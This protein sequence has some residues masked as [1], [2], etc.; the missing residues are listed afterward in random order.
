[1]TQRVHDNSPSPA[2]AARQVHGGPPGPLSVWVLADL[3]KDSIL[4]QMKWD[5]SAFIH[6]VGGLQRTA[7]IAPV[8]KHEDAICRKFLYFAGNAEIVE[9]LQRGLTLIVFYHVALHSL[10]ISVDLSE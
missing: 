3:R 5:P 1:M 6:G 10:G 7:P 8:Q 9:C 4:D 2:P